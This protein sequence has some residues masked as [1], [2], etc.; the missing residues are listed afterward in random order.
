MTAS[1]PPAVVWPAA[2][3]A[4]NTARTT[5]ARGGLSTRPSTR[6]NS[7]TAP[8]SPAWACLPA[9]AL[10]GSA[11]PDRAITEFAR[12]GSQQEPVLFEPRGGG[13]VGAGAYDFRAEEQLP[14]RDR[15]DRNRRREDDLDF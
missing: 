5:R 7:R 8:R 3:Q 11:E 4:M 14:G 6:R 13:V 12:S 9:A 1:R 2:G 10:S 15:L